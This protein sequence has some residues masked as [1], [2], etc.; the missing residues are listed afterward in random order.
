M[1]KITKI[2]FL[3]F[4]CL[5]V[6][7]VGCGFFN[8]QNRQPID[9]EVTLGGKPVETGRIEFSPIG[10]PDNYT[11]SGA[12]ITNG[13]YSIPRSKGLAPGEYGVRI[14]VLEEFPLEKTEESDPD[15][16]FRNAAPPEFGNQSTQKVTVESGKK[17]KFDF[18]M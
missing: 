6:C 2:Y 5:L 9:G 15:T 16:G 11:L 4:T 7:V 14:V 12:T 18:N 8:S 3:L 10:N 1:N 13:R 17:N